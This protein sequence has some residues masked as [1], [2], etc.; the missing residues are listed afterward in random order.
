[1]TI[2]SAEGKTH[3]H[4]SNGEWGPEPE[5]GER[6]KEGAWPGGAQRGAL[7]TMSSVKEAALSQDLELKPW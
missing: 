7:V 2:T 6:D 5:A 1:M 4:L 3:S